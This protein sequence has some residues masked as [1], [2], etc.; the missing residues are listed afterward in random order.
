MRVRQT[1]SQ[2]NRLVLGDCRMPPT[3]D[4]LAT[5][6]VVLDRK[7][8]QDG[9]KT[10]V[11]AAYNPIHGAWF[12]QLLP[13][14][15]RPAVPGFSSSFV[16]AVSSL[17]LYFLTPTTVARRSRFLVFNPVTGSFRLLPELAVPKHSSGSG[18]KLVPMVGAGAARRGNGGLYRVVLVTFVVHGRD[19][20]SITHV[21]RSDIDCWR[22][23]KSFK[24]NDKEEW[25]GTGEWGPK[26]ACSSGRLAYFTFKTEERPWTRKLMAFD[27]VEEKWSK[28][29][30][31]AF[32]SDN[33]FV[34]SH[35]ALARYPS[36]LVCLGHLIVVIQGNR[37]VS[38]IQKTT[39]TPARHQAAS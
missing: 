12:R 31:P 28:V 13:W 33:K 21:Y 10:L 29:T 35:P 1:C 4:R 30:V 11:A 3:Q 27:V 26:G 34:G 16:E 22:S 7:I 25:P 39:G 2:W 6:T 38:L 14:H 8:V 9:K 32:S 17:L 18:V 37:R 36:F 5:L 24:L 19:R 20:R 23:S 15:R